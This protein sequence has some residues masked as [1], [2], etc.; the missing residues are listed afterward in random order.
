MNLIKALDDRAGPKKNIGSS[1][2]ASNTVG[3]NLFGAQ[4]ET[5]IL[6]L[7]YNPEKNISRFSS[8]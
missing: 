5:K 1:Q 8:T 3:H 6:I 7:I 4:T 2:A